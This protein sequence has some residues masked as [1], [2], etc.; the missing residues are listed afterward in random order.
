MTL[1]TITP[2]AV[3]PITA[4]D[5]VTQLHLR[6]DV[7][8]VEEQDLIAAYAESACARAQAMTRTRFITQTV[9]LRL[10][11]FGCG[12][13]EAIPL[14]IAPIQSIA[15]VRYIDGGGVQQVLPSSDYRLVRSR[16]PY[17]LWPRYGQTWP[18]PRADADVVEIDIVVGYGDTGADVPA[19]IRQ[20]LRLMIAAMF[21]NRDNV[22]HGS[23]PVELPEGARQLL[24]AHT[25]WV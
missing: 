17:E 10:D 22:V 18:V 6:I 14:P 12:V 2:P 15:A 19:D 20:A 21:D 13:G 4:G 1:H 16:V 11:A 23:A 9:Q 3:L 7:D 8:E 25:L 24:S 5:I